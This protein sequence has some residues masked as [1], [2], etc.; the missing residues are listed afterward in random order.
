MIKNGSNSSSLEKQK[1]PIIECV[2]NFSEGRDVAKIEYIRQ[3]IA[4]VEG[5]NVLHI[6][7]GYDANR[8]VITF[9][10]TP[11]G[12]EEAAYRAI[13]A[14]SEVID[15]RQQAGEHPRI[16]AT[17][18]MPLI[19]VVGMTIEDV[20]VISHRLSQRVATELA[21][22]VFNYE[23]SAITSQRKHLESIR[24]GEYEHLQKK[25][26]SPEWKPDY[27]AVFNAKSGATVIGA[28][29][30]LL[31]YN[32]NLNTLDVKVAKTIAALIRESGSIVNGKR[33]KGYFCGVKAIGWDMPEYGMT[34]VSTNITHI[35]LVTLSQLYEKVK[36]LA[37]EQGVDVVGSELIGLAPLKCLLDA[38]R[39]YAPTLENEKEVITKAIDA[40]GLNS[41]VPF[42]LEKRI[43]EYLL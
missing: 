3:A 13:K 22:P 41:V 20:V 12:V 42:E 34:Q 43:I 15:M 31:A 14:A 19:P 9:A 33:Q 24:K 18:V 37:A 17:D 21:I 2:P 32:I 8:T 27:G 28:R 10:G 26:S 6:D 4:H 40:L 35:E 16:G 36:A 7:S 29:P 38:G 11:E 30:F 5:V 1:E 23:K 25:M 39:F